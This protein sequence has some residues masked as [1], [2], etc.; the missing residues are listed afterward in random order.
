MVDGEDQAW[1]RSEQ[2]AMQQVVSC[3]LAGRRAMR[4]LQVPTTT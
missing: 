4:I 3:R 1:L 2:P